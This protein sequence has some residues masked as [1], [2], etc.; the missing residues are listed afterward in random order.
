M[1]CDFEQLHAYSDCFEPDVF[2]IIPIKNADIGM[3]GNDIR[4]VFDCA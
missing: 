4:R 2:V 1:R 3:L